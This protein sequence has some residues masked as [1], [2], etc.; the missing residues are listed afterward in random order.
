MRKM[1]LPQPGPGYKTEWFQGSDQFLVLK[2]FMPGW[3][4]GDYF[5]FSNLTYNLQY[6]NGTT[7]KCRLEASLDSPKNLTQA[8]TS[9][10][11][12]EY[13]QINIWCLTCHFRINQVNLTNS[14]QSY[15]NSLSKVSVFKRKTFSPFI[16]YAALKIKY[17]IMK[18]AKKKQLKI[19]GNIGNRKFIV[20][21][22]RGRDRPQALSKYRGNQLVNKIESY[23]VFNNN[24]I[25]YLMT[26]L[27]QDHAQI[28][29][30]RTYFKDFIFQDLDIELFKHNSFQKMGSYLVYVTE[31]ALQDISD[32]IVRTYSDH[33]LPNKEKE[34][35][36]LSS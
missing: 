34:L 9:V 2:R 25:V 17:I 21:H 26:D 1:F 20:I 19:N 13:S 5:D 15:D 7:K 28:K 32:G 18:T 12:L 33:T 29:A 36:F 10:L 22:L 16:K 3:T 30:V 11:T 14:V 35:G 31:M 24:S 27:P 4:F 23:G 6:A 8:A